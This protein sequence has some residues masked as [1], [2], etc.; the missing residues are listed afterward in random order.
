M[1]SYLYCRKVV[2][3][4]NKGFYKAFSMLPFEKA[5]ALYAVYAFYIEARNAVVIKNDIHLLER[6][7][8]YINDIYSGVYVNDHVFIALKD[9]IKRYNLQKK[10]FLD[11]IKGIKFDFYH[12]YTKTESELEEYCY[13]VSETRYLLLTPVIAS[14]AYSENSELLNIIAKNLGYAMEISKLLKTIGDDIDNDQVYLSMEMIDKH[15]ASV[16]DLKNKVI[17]EEYVSLVNDYINKAKE[18]FDVFYD[19]I[20]LYDKDSRF[21]L[22]ITA[23]YSDATLKKIKKN[24][25]QNLDTI[26]KLS[27]LERSIL[28][29]KEKINY[30][31]KNKKS[32]K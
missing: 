20:H 8:D 5:S 3:T 4:N 29:T 22:Y 12:K 31:L 30:L 13:Y 2:K 17:T 28:T 32:P 7:K 10:Y 9:A 25:Y 26:T 24:K 21:P 11:M 6:K 14:E 23:K 18:S 1:E 16:Y 19:N 15:H 27:F